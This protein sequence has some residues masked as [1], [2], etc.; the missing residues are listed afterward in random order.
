MINST[1]YEQNNITIESLI[2]T[3]PGNTKVY[4]HLGWILVIIIKINKHIVI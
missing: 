4:T 3:D 1:S 2:L